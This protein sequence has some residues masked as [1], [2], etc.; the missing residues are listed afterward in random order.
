MATAQELAD[1]TA[2]LRS[3][4]A[5]YLTAIDL[6]VDGGATGAFLHP[7]SPATQNTHGMRST[8][9]SSGVVAVPGQVPHR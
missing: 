1:T 8:T 9:R 4:R 5:R 7:I 3:D 6:L 2:F